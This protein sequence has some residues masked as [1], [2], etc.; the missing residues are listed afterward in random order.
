MIVL[1]QEGFVGVVGYGDTGLT[2]AAAVGI[3]EI[4]KAQLMGIT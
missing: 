2:R 4:A 1:D 3:V